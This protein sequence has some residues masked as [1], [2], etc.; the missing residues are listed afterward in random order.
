MPAFLVTGLWCLSTHWTLSSECGLREEALRVRVTLY[1]DRSA[2]SLRGTTSGS[3]DTVLILRGPC[4]AAALSANAIFLQTG[5]STV[6]QATTLL[7]SQ[8]HSSV[9]T[10]LPSW[11]AG[12]PQVRG[13]CSGPL[14]LGPQHSA[15]SECSGSALWL[16]PLLP[17]PSPSLG[18]S[19]TQP[20]D[21][22][23]TRCQA[24]LLR[25]TW[26]QPPL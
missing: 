5:E 6:H 23:P 18:P 12:D 4:S 24:C 22:G 2:L 9:R 26:A 21:Q 3:A 8:S 19:G 10:P 14:T 7:H 17:A 25:S 11:L 13:D 20:R 15:E 16:H 1:A